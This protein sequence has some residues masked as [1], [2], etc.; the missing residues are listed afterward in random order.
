MSYLNIPQPC[1]RQWNEMTPNEKGRFCSSCSKNIPDLTGLSQRQLAE[2]W[3]KSGGDMC[4]RLTPVQLRENYVN[5][6]MRR[7][8]VKQLQKFCLA[9]LVSFGASLF[10]IGNASAHK[11]I[12]SV[13]SM[14]ISTRTDTLQGASI[15]G[16][17]K[18]KKSKEDLPFVTVMLLK[19][20]S[21]IAGCYS[22]IDGNF[23]LKVPPGTGN[24]LSLKVA[25]IGYQTVLITNISLSG[26][27]KMSIEM[28]PA[29]LG[30]M[31]GVIIN[32]DE[33]SFPEDGLDGTKKTVKRKQY[34][35]MPH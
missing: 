4:G 29:D 35:R 22:D 21:V 20:D 13:R 25:Y 6:M 33:M 31:I 16:T 8:W 34:K 27:T 17:I 30:P 5:G 18:D 26:D 1:H 11:A 10:F 19:N 28:E 3:E 12:T 23:V 32:T 9:L 2:A 14:F 15:K 24:R 7:E